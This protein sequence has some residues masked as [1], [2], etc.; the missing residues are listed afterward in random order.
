MS[1]FIDITG[2]KFGRLTVI[3]RS[4]PNNKKRGTYWSCLCECGNTKVVVG[5]NLKNGTTKSCGCIHR[6]QLIERCF[7]DI[8]GKRYGR[9]TA[10]ERV[11]N[12]VSANGSRRTRWKCRCDCGNEV[13]VNY[14]DIVIGRT[15]SCK[16]IFKLEPGEASFN[17]LYYSYK[18]SGRANRNNKHA[19]SARNIFKITKDQFREL[20][21]KNCYYCGR[22][23]SSVALYKNGNGEYL[24][25]GLD[26]VDND[27]GYTLDNV[28]TC[29]GEC[30]YYK[31][32][33]TQDDFISWLKRIANYWKP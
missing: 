23:P 6:E 32:S 19:N 27:K 24:Y 3:K 9:L 4:M 33:K 22:E 17:R 21:K 5:S 20:T 25:N 29:C 12:A 31:G 16:C 10:I 1:G 28:V 7:I 8:T 13:I 15:Q 26:R 11:E 14:V 30:N 18:N 2:Q